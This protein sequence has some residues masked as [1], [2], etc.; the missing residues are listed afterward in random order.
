[1]LS[2][3]RFIDRIWYEHNFVLIFIAIRSTF[4][5]SFRFSV[6][7]Y[8]DGHKIE[9]GPVK[10]VFCTAFR[11][12]PCYISF[13]VKEA[14]H[15]HG[16]IASNFYASP[17]EDLCHLAIE[18][19]GKKDKFRIYSK[20]MDG[21]NP[22]LVALDQNGKDENYAYYAPGA[23]EKPEIAKLSDTITYSMYKSE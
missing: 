4:L 21:E 10:S 13:I 18:H 1:M 9:A 15:S 3:H 16:P 19:I 7:A 22:I 14:T 2:L 12:T 17:S 20:Q 8:S 5:K 6:S 11:N 23:F